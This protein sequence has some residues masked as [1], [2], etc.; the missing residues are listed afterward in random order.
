MGSLLQQ[1]LLPSTQPLLS[2][3][4]F[5]LTHPQVWACVWDVVVAMVA[6]ADMAGAADLCT[7][8][9]AASA[10]WAWAVSAVADVA[11]ASIAIAAGED[12]AALAVVV[13][14]VVDAAVGKL[15]C[16]PP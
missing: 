1:I 4:K 11:L 7:A 2:F 16:I 9:A 6:T 14:A 15:S 5:L 12:R 3:S 8:G 10:A 13:L